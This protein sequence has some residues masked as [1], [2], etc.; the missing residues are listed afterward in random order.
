MKET[1]PIRK[2]LPLPDKD[3]S[4]TIKIIS[5]PRFVADVSYPEKGGIIATCEIYGKE[6]CPEYDLKISYNIYEGISK[7][8]KKNNIQI[9]SDLE[10]LVGHIFTITRIGWSDKFKE[11]IYGI[12]IRLDL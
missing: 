10:C 7:E 4:I 9:D 11:A 5:P 12:N 6:Y 1:I 2:L 3:E 8:L